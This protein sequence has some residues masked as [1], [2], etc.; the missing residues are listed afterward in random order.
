MNVQV[1]NGP[2]LSLATALWRAGPI[3][4][5]SPAAALG[6]MDPRLYSG[7]GPGGKGK[8]AKGVSEERLTP[9]VENHAHK[10]T[11]TGEVALSF[12][13]CSTRGE[14]MCPAPCW[15]STAEM[16][17]V[18]AAKVSQTQGQESWTN[19]LSARRW[20]GMMHPFPLSPAAVRRAGARILRADELAL[21]LEGSRTQE[22][23]LCTATVQHSGAGTGGEGTSEP[24]LSCWECESYPIPSQT[25]AFVIDWAAQ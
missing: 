24:A 6:R 18:V 17:W 11:S 16:T 25:A 22:S 20:W 3:S 23:R 8:L 15:D 9:A 5:P 21:P 19:H 13:S 4:H 1:Q 7:T 14:Q 10:V 2:H 12:T